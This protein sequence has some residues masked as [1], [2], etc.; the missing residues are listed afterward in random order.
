MRV[1]LT[2]PGAAR[3]RIKRAPG[4]RPLSPLPPAPGC[5]ERGGAA[6]SGGG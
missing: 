1:W 4:G 2:K 3:P 6:P 5:S